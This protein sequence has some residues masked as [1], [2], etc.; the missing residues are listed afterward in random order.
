MQPNESADK[1]LARRP[2]EK[3]AV[4]NTKCKEQGLQHSYRANQQIS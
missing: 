3:T 2:N 1:K 4:V